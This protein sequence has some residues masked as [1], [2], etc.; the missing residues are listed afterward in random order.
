MYENRRTRV[1][2]RGTAVAIY[3]R[4]TGGERASD[5]RPTTCDRVPC[6]VP[7]KAVVR[8]R[9]KFSRKRARRPTRIT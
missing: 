5:A 4:W 1:I 8:R 7:S 2:E 6:E 3:T 9:V